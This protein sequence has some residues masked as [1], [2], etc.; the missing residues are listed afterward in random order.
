MVSF[1]G[2]VRLDVRLDPDFALSADVENPLFEFSVKSKQT[3]EAVDEWNNGKI[4]KA[5]DAA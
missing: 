1:S 5:V 2:Q 3:N 4:N